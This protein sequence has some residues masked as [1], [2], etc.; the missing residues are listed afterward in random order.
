MA[1]QQL[2]IAHARIFYPQNK[3]EIFQDFLKINN[4]Q[5]VQLKSQ[6]ARDHQSLK[7]SP[8]QSVFKCIS[9]VQKLIDKQQKEEYEGWTLEQEKVLKQKLKNFIDQ[10]EKQRDSN[11][12]QKQGLED[13]LLKLVNQDKMDA[14]MSEYGSMAQNRRYRSLQ[15]RTNSTERNL[16]LANMAQRRHQ[17]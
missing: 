14:T 15:S 10:N 5:S 16:R 6:N 3:H 1:N 7:L 12:I 8:R 4:N 9:K 11:K 17:N 2:L 13:I